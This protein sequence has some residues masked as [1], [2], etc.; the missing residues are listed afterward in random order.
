MYWR[1]G[2]ARDGNAKRARCDAAAAGM[3]R[4]VSTALHKPLHGPMR[5]SLR[6]PLRMPLRTPPIP[7]APRGYR[8]GP[9]NPVD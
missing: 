5:A 1:R 7:C 6:A 9:R 2:G 3:R 8:A 4:A